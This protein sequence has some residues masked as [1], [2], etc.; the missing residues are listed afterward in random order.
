MVLATPALAKRSLGQSGRYVRSR[1]GRARALSVAIMKTCF[2]YTVN[3][4]YLVPALVSALGARARVAADVADVFICDV[5]PRTTV[6]ERVAII[7]AARGIRYLPVEPSVLDGLPVAYA[8]LFMTHFL[9]AEYESIVYLDAD[10]QVWGDMTPLAQ[11][12][13]SD[14]RVLAVRDPITAM[15]DAD[16]SYK[17]EHIAHL[18]ALGLPETARTRYF[19]S[20]MIKASRETWAEV[21]AATAA[22]SKVSPRTVYVDQD[23]LNQIA[24]ER[25]DPISARWNYPG[26]LLGTRMER[27]VKPSFVHFMSNPRPWHGAFQPWGPRGVVPY[28]ELETDYPD[29]APYRPRLTPFKHL[30]Y[31]AQRRVLRLIKGNEWQSDAFFKSYMDLNAQ[32]P[33]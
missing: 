27:E 19:N 30:K 1:L 18:E 32:T 5:G 7:C 20:G 3:S 23:T 26:F 2:V 9:P 21:G 15:I 4:G 8:R 33:F 16:L 25:L 13:V 14:G 22:K 12:P 31:A 29:L 10:S 11:A 24:L 6:G 28:T 17:A